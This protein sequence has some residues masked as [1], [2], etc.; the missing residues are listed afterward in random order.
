[1]KVNWK[2]VIPA[3][4]TPFNA[5][6]TV[7]EGFLAKHSRWLVDEGCVGLV[8]IGSLGESATLNPAEK[9]KVMEICVKA[10]GDRVPVIPG[11]D[12]PAWRRVRVRSSKCLNNIIE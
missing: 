12:H 3:I 5:D 9:R 4:T 2:G 7:D 8:P 10:V 11:I 6:F 1:M